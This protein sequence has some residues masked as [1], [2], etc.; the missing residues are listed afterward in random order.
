MT[1][2]AY[3]L[4]VFVISAIGVGYYITTRKEIVHLKHELSQS[5]SG[6]VDKTKS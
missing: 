1:A 2:L 4:L 3:R 5:E 6:G